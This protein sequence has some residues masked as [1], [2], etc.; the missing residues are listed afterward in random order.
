MSK[1]IYSIKNYHAIKQAD[2]V[3]DGITV[4]S[5]E[6]GCGKS[7]MSRWLYYMING[8]ADFEKILF[9]E[10]VTYIQELVG[11]WEVVYRDIQ[12]T[13][14]GTFFKSSQSGFNK[15]GTSQFEH[16]LMLEKFNTDDIQRTQNIF[17]Q[18]LF[19]FA[20]QLYVY[21][22]EE[23]REI[24]KNRVLNFL[25]INLKEYPTLRDNINAFVKKYERLVER[26]TQSL[27]SCIRNRS[28]TDFVR[29]VN[30]KF[31]ETDNF[32][33]E[34]QLCEDGLELLDNGCLA[35]IY[36]LHKAIYID[37]PMSI[38]SKGY[39]NYFW[40]ELRDIIMSPSSRYIYADTKYLIKR[41]KNLL[42]G[43]AKL[44][45]NEV[46]E[47]LKEIRYVSDDNEIDIELYKVA[48]GIKTFI[49]L[50]RL[51]QNGCL[52]DSTL[53]LIDEP[54]AHLHPQW[55]VEYARL[56]VLINKKLGTKIMLASH[57]PDMVAAIRA[58]AEKEKVLDK[59]NFYL[60][61]RFDGCHQYIYKNLGNEI[62]EIFRS[63][64]IALDR[65]KQYG[66]D[67]I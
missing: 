40:N 30:H 52:T 2:I 22:D 9:Q 65:I 29:I 66:N 7:T 3:I 18:T 23:N 27:F 1:Y 42:G 58:I 31:D 15:I 47:D 13:N 46:F 60:A 48:T 39:D 41:V 6:N 4:L 64:N 54:E 17:L 11:R 34:L 26:K 21:I 63:F 5:G 35:T 33:S 38:T 19:A 16:L 36:N 62:G 55:I 43:E 45:E 50:Q 51:L 20:D 56:L 28:I 14:T 44:V 57:N 61:K 32:P 10:Y 67:S 25:E 12:R 59:T 49:Y 37:T 53:L 8:S 24:R